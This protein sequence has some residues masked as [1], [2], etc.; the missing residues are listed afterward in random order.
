MLLWTW[1]KTFWA[2]SCA[3]SGSFNTR[4]AK[5]LNKLLGRVG[6][7][8]DDHYHSHL[9]LSLAEVANAL[10]YVR[11]NARRHFGERASGYFSSDHPGWAELLAA[12]SSLR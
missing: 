8:F 7:V 9:L 5:G 1:T 6:G 10:A 4:L 3:S 11:D 2:T 12:D